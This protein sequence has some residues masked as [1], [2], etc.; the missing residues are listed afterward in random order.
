MRGR[1]IY[2]IL[3][4]INGKRYIG[5][6][7]SF[8]Q[9]NAVHLSLLRKGN[10][11]SRHLQNAWNL[12]GEKAFAFEVL[13]YVIDP[14]Q[15]IEREQF[16]IDRLK[17]EYNICPA[18]GSNL[19]RKFG[20]LSKEHRHKL[21]EAQKR[22]FQ[23]PEARQKISERLRGNAYSLGHK[24]TEE[25]RQ[26]MSEAHRLRYRDPEERQKTS[27]ASKR[28]WQNPEH[29][30]KMSKIQRGEGNG[31]ARLSESDVI[32]IKALLQEGDLSHR[33]IAARF[34]VARSSISSINRGRVWKHV[35]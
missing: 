21:G 12:Y 15:L 22:R 4:R 2:Q 9:R 19:G 13:E 28:M 3:N 1:G 8:K 14:E 7:M 11:H 18:A 25:T 10:H 5:S 17:P 31:N 6:A 35:H 32:E 16:Y 23:D 26:K 24:H 29:R 34:G 33:E 20:P 30:R 27:E